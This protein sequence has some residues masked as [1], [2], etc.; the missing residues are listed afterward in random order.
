MLRFSTD[1]HPLSLLRDELPAET[2][3]RDRFSALPNLHGG[4]QAPNGGLIR[5]DEPVP[6][7]PQALEGPDGIE[8]LPDAAN[9]PRLLQENDTRMLLSPCRGGG[10][11]LAL[12]EFTDFVTKTRKDGC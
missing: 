3:T 4:I 2:V 10:M 12:G 7:P 9:T 6:R 8:C 11:S 1:L 5:F